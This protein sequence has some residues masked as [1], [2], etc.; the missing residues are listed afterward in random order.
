MSTS[1]LSDLVRSPDGP[2]VLVWCAAEQA[3]G[4]W[5]STVPA[6][7]CRVLLADDNQMRRIEPFYTELTRAGLLWQSMGQNWNAFE[8]VLYDPDVTADSYVLIVSR[9]DAILASE[10]HIDSRC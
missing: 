4:E 7:K 10:P 3:V 5:I 8:E 1:K 9:S 2:W 6:H